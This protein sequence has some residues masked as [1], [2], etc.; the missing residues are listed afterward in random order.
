[1]VANEIPGVRL[2]TAV[3]YYFILPG[4][5]SNQAY[6]DGPFPAANSLEEAL[7]DSTS[8]VSIFMKCRQDVHDKVCDFSSVKPPGSY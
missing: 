4:S 2:H 8:I 1:M 7:K 5:N 6:K 3:P